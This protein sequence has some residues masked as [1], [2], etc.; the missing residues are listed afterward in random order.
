[1]ASQPI[2]L[3]TL[4]GDAGMTV[5]VSPYGG[6]LQS[7]RV[8]DRLGRSVNV[9]LGFATLAEYVANVTGS[10]A[11]ASGSAHFGALIGRYANR[12]AGPSFV[13]EGQRYELAGNDGPANSITLHGGPGGGYSGAVWQGGVDSTVP[14]AAVRLRHVDPDGKNGFPGTVEIEVV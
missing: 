5:S 14:G 1:M 12:I 10:D 3:Y 2:E 9:A 7:I 8:P 11:S 4:S 6:V 13:L